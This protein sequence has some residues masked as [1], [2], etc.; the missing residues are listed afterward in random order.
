MQKKL[1]SRLIYQGK[2]FHVTQDKV[3]IENGNHVTR[4]IVH[5]HGGVGVVATINHQILLVKQFR[6]ATMQDLYEIPAGKLEQGEDPL[7]CGI[8]ELEEETAYRCTLMKPI[9]SFYSTPGFCSE[10]IHLFEAIDPKHVENPI[11]MDD[12]ECIDICWVDIQQAMHMISS[13]EIKDAKTIISIQYA[14]LKETLFR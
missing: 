14:M 9:T 11:P 6:Y 12:D 4:D 3:E 5:H 1:S 8:R 13:G 10:K 7:T 2:I